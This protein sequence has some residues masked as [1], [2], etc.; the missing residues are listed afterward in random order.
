MGE[1]KEEKITKIQIINCR[2]LEKSVLNDKVIEVLIQNPKLIETS[3]ISS[4][5]INYEVSTPAMNWLVFRRYSDFLWI[6][7]VLVKLLTSVHDVFHQFQIKNQEEEDLKK[8]LL[9][10]E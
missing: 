10:K 6:R 2:K 5:Y 8:I 7:N 1:T 4:N 3:F 9:K